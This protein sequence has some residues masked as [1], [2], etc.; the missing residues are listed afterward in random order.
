[1]ANRDPAVLFY[2]DT[3][4]TATAEMDSDVRGWYLN[5]I[6]HHFDKKDLPNDIEK[7]ALLAGVKFSEFERFKQMFEQVL[8][9]KFTKNDSDRLENSY[10]KQILQS[11]KQFKDKRSKSGNIG[12]VIKVALELGFNKNEINKLK[13]ELHSFDS[14]KID[15]YK[16]KHLLEQ[17]LKQM[18]KLYINK[19]KNEDIIDIKDNKEDIEDIEFNYKKSLL[20]LVGSEQLVKD[21]LLVRK[22][23]KLTNTQTGF[24]TLEEQIELS[25]K[26]ANEIIKLCVERSWGSFKKEWLENI[27]L[28]EVKKQLTEEDKKQAT[29]EKF[30]K[31]GWSEENIKLV[32]ENNVW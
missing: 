30:R 4:L 23:K 10:A 31:I 17:M 14:D 11:R 18:R 15:T 25:G 12:V 29:I 21:F 5:L 19:D 26:P 22:N 8:M 20:K 27:G 13:T 9:Q 7:L 6:L 1:V 2:I 3:W 32:T 24:E 16:N 28:P